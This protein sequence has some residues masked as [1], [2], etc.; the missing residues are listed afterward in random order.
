MF[1]LA[2]TPAEEA[3]R[4]EL[5]AWLEAHLPR[6]PAPEDEGERRRF[7]RAWQRALAAGGW[8]GMQCPRAHGGR[9]RG[10]RE[11]I[12]FTEEMARVRAPEL[13]APGTVD[14]CGPIL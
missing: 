6:A 9:G 12:I 14:I 7:Q 13:L 5:R 11:Q 10:L 4:A 2:Y 1:G 8:V 3:F